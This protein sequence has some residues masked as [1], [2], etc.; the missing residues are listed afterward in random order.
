MKKT[1]EKDDDQI[2]HKNADYNADDQI[3]DKNCDYNADD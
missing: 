1:F 3:N 2:N